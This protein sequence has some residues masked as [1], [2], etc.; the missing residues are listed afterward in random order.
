MKKESSFR[1]IPF[2]YTS[3]SDK[4]IILTFFPPEFWGIL[5]N[6]KERRVTGRSAKLLFEVL[7]DLFIIDRNPYLYDD[8]LGNSH[9]RARLAAL[10]RAKMA[11]VLERTDMDDVRKI[12]TETLRL[13]E[14]FFARMKHEHR[15]RLKT[16][17]AFGPITARR[18]IQFSPFHKVS[19]VTDATDWRVQYP[20]AVAFPGTLK[21]IPRLIRKAR[22]LG[23]KIIPRGGGT[24][25]TGGAVPTRRNTLVINTEKLRTIHG[26]S[27]EPSP[28]GAIPV[29]S[30]DAGA[31]TDDVTDYCEE[32]GLI[33]AT[34]PTSGWASTIGGNI[35]EN[36][37]GKKALM[38]GTAIDNLY[39][40]RMYDPAGK[41][42]EI[43]RK[44][45]PYR[46]ILADDIVEFEVYA[47][48]GKHKELQRTIT[49][50]GTDVRK[51]GLGKDITNKALGGVPGLQKEGGDGIIISA[52]FVLYEPWPAVATIC[53]EVFGE[54]MTAAAEA[55]VR[56]RDL[57]QNDPFVRLTALEHFDDK[58][59]NAIQYRNKSHRE[60]IPKA[61][62]LIDVETK[63]EE[64]IADA[65]SKLINEVMPY[66]VEA[67]VAQLPAARE[68]FWK[69]RKNL[70]AIARHTNAFKLNEDIVI[71]IE[72]LSAFA[73]FV[74][75]LNQQKQRE[76]LSRLTLAALN[77]LQDTAFDADEFIQAKREIFRATLLSL[78]D[79]I[80]SC[81][82]ANNGLQ[83]DL[84]ARFE[85]SFHGYSEII[86]RFRSI[87]AGILSKTIVLATHMHAGDGNIHVNIPVNSNDYG[88]LKDAENTVT[89][90]FHKTT[91]LG[92]VISGEHGI[93][94]TKLQFLSRNVIDEY[95]N[96]K[97]SIDPDDLFNP[98]KLTADFNHNSIY[99]PSLNLLEVEAFILEATELRS[100]TEQVSACVRCGKCKQPCHT[101][102]PKATMF[103]SPRN[104]ILAL[105]LI[106][107]AVLYEAQVHHQLNSRQLRNMSEIAKHCTLCHK[108]Q[109]PCPVSID[110]GKVT[111]AIRELLGERKVVR[112]A[113]LTASALAYLSLK[114]YYSNV[115][116]GTFLYRALYPLQNLAYHVN[117]PI[118]RF[119]RRLLGGMSAPIASKLPKGGGQTVRERFHLSHS[120]RCYAFTLPQPKI[121]K[122]VLYF[123]GCGSER[124]FPD[125]C[126]A[127]LTLLHG[128]GVR[129][130]LPPEYLCCGYPFLSNGKAELAKAR[131]YRNSVIL[132]RMANTLSYMNIK[133]I[134]VSCG[135]CFEMLEQ[136]QLSSIFPKARIID[137]AEFLAEDSTFKPGLS[138]LQQL[139]YHTACHS[140]I[141]N[142]EPAVLFARL[143]GQKPH[144]P[145]HCCGE[146]GTMALSYSS[147]SNTLRERKNKAI[148]ECTGEEKTTVLA[149][150]PSCIQGL[151]REEQ[152]KHHTGKHLAVFMAE[153]LY[154]VDY[155]E[156]FVKAMD[157]T[158]G[159]ES[160]LL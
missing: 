128:Q 18:N 48:R 24:G 159:I 21:E 142:Q 115:L 116:V 4:E 107:E 74:D 127:T 1:E 135:T 131:R 8:Y 81:R 71:P 103:Y 94:L 22:R 43:H 145:P 155:G 7:G 50:S 140:P 37:G 105:S 45:H 47:V 25:L 29:I 68:K 40:F 113:P 102:H 126:L 9:G 13:S 12:A 87:H 109:I 150:C 76:T 32:R 2:N 23:L 15:L 55:I 69:D 19:H 11:T 41:L 10:H 30:V 65:C 154:G 151:S 64:F 26:I 133:E 124:M 79:E 152:T 89:A 121:T 51:K 46:K 90:V 148:K 101:N 125:V 54:N 67:F 42:L 104:K 84:L 129:T 80:A 86:A 143:F 62:L 136:Y 82:I 66:N 110:F 117:R 153:Q 28:I 160:I 92:G 134:I 88:M 114:D 63:G 31:I 34:D 123:P 36:S 120:D 33:F 77:F 132:H 137:I 38:W 39:S 122:S 96:Y 52:E 99:T 75:D 111:L 61:V 44:D 73:S 20:F 144:L 49:L 58:Y 53:L 35:A 147:L 146:G 83:R 3:F 97:S 59:V 138:P 57:F 141:K 118:A 5:E 60:A 106:V 100:L 156:K 119:T 85:Q 14:S 78:R 130:V 27:H 98:D 91:E 158:K 72:S 112:L 95:Q 6:L 17:A 139:T 93:G 108:C 157:E 149:S 56:V 16:L 70:G